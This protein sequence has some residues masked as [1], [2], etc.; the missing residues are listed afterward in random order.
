M[1]KEILL[2]KAVSRAC[3]TPNTNIIVSGYNLL[4][5]MT[6]NMATESEYEDEEVRETMENHFEIA[7]EFREI[8][9]G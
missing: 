2:E 7:K 1:D 6:G 4:T 5:V 3:W 8:E 9:F